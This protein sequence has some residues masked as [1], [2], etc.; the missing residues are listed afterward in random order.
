[1]SQKEKNRAISEDKKEGEIVT[2]EA[3]EAVGEAKLLRSLR[4]TESRVT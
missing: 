1:M 3:E 2:N 4:P